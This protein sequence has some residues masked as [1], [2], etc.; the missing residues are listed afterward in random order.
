MTSNLK[1]ANLL[2]NVKLRRRESGLPRE[3]VVNVTQIAK[4]ARSAVAK[5]IGQLSRG[6]LHDVWNGLRLVLEPPSEFSL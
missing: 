6:R 3:S 1:H 2:G 4:V 5:R